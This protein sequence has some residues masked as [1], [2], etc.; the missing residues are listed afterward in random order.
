MV[1]LDAATQIHL[2]WS[3]THAEHRVADSVVV[4]VHDHTVLSAATCVVVRTNHVPAWASP[5][6]INVLPRGVV[7]PRYACG[8]VGE[9]L[10]LDV[11]PAPEGTFAVGVN[12]RPALHDLTLGDG[13]V[14]GLGV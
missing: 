10:H 12:V 7:Q 2:D 11:R 5:A 3:E 13:R 8:V 14:D 1:A 6:A 4:G 9:K